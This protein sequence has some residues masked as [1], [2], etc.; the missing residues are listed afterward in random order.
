MKCTENMAYMGER[1]AACTV[2]MRKPEGKRPVGKPRRRWV[3]NIRCILKKS[4][5][6]SWIGLI[7]LRIGW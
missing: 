3:D 5:A 7:W 6:R 1:K 4:V 2:L